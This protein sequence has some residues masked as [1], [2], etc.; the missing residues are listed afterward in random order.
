MKKDLLT[1]SAPEQS[2]SSTL[3]EVL[4]LSIA[5]ACFATAGASSAYAQEEIVLPTVNVETTEETPAAPAAPRR[6]TNTRR[7]AAPAAPQTC[8]PEFAGTPVCAAQEAAEAQAAAEAAAAAQAAAQASAGTNPYAD[9][10]A[11]FKADTLSNSK[12]PGEIIDTPRTVTAITKEVLDTTGTTSVREIARSTPGI[13]LGF[14][15]GGNSYGD[16]LYIRGFKST[17]DLYLDGVR[18]P[19]TAIHETFNTEQI[20]IVKGP[21][22]TV[23]GRGTAGGAIDA[24]SKKPQDVDFNKVTGEVTSAGTKRVTADV[25]RAVNDRFQYRLNGMYQDGAVAG[26]E[27]VEDDRLGASIATRYK[28]MDNFT[29]ELDYSYTKMDG[30]PDWGV[31]YIAGRG[32]ITSLGVDRDTWYGITDRD[33]QKSTQSVGTARGIFEF[34]NGMTLTNTLR[35]S[36]SILDYVASV[37]SGIETNDSKDPDDWLVAVGGKSVY[38]ETYVLSDTLELTGEQYWGG[39]KHAL[40]FGANFTEENVKK[41]GYDNLTSEDYQAPDGFRGCAVSAT[42]PDQEAEGCWNGDDPVR[43]SNG[44]ETNVITHSLYAMDTV[45]LNDQWQINGGVR[46][47]MYDITRKGTD[48]R[49]GEAY[50]YDRKDTM[51]NWNAGVTYKPQDNLS[52]YGAV[53]TSTTPMG[54]EIASG[55]S[56]FYGGLDENGQ[57]LKPEQNTSY[58]IG[59]KYSY[60][61][62]LL[63]TAALFQTIRENGREDVTTV[64]PVTFERSSTTDDTLKYKMEGIELGVSG[65]I[66]D[67][68]GL[69]GGGTWMRSEILDAS[70]DDYKGK[71]LPNISHSQ[72]NLLG[73]YDFTDELMLGLRAN[74]Q[75]EKDLGTTVPNGNTL[76]EAWTW[77]MVGSYDINDQAE[78]RFGITN[79]TDVTYYD[80]AYRSGSPFTY[81]APG[82]EVS[83]SIDFRF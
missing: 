21:A 58:E 61:D 65:R 51:W 35:S 20:E 77:D 62:N 52:F 5:A 44:T 41:W 31:P 10:D 76:Q 43:S 18:D 71:R 83:V 47:D 37:P 11:P 29:L 19:G 74:F 16:N 1:V 33:F 22:S 34:D 40:T 73:T 13:S 69:F 14:G 3:G 23:G 56:S 50:E 79:L 49:S 48:F 28:V 38:Q 30:Q 36:T 66:G 60:N 55:G 17:N 9:P 12:L 8:T 81:V 59:A 80:S 57:D 4:G 2:K 78:V 45:E 27:N 53:A 32:P 7:A 75:G 46:V 39:R 26:R 70:T 63:L 54:Q 24:V 67:K 68:I 25:N 82:R 42:D 72:F 6:T 64:D 15:E